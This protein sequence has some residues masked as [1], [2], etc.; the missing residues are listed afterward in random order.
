MATKKYKETVAS[1]IALAVG[2]FLLGRVMRRDKEEL[3]GLEDED[4]NKE[5][6]TEQA[7]LNNLKKLVAAKRKIYVYY[8][9]KNG[10]YTVSTIKLE[11]G[12][13]FYQIQFV[14]PGT[15]I[16]KTLYPRHVDN[17]RKTKEIT[18]FQ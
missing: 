7:V 1:V 11:E 13:Q 4:F 9:W 15:H 8:D 5:Y 6:S 3:S 17:W 10:K 2:A 12:D 18:L 16:M 14:A